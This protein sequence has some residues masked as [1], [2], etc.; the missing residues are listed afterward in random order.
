[1]VSSPYWNN[2]VANSN[3]GAMTWGNGNS[4]STG[5]VSAGNSLIGTT[6]DDQ[7]SLQGA[8]LLSDGNY[9][10]PSSTW[11][12]VAFTAAGA[13]TLASSNFRLKGTIQAWNSVRGFANG[14]GSAMVSAGGLYPVHSYD[15]A[16]HRLAVGRPAE[17]IVSL[18]T[19]DQIFA[20]DLEP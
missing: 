7:V 4:G 1:V 5:A 16:R 14:G 20:G 13:V 2:A 6:T 19:M 12:N 18:F 11:I 9:V 3:F 8:R 17:N 10:V 15:T